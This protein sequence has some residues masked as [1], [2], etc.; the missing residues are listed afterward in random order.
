MSAVY[1]LESP[2]HPG[3][4]L[5]RKI[6]EP[7]NLTVMS[8]ASV[9]GVTRQFLSEFLNEKIDLN[10]DLAFRIEKVFGF[11]ME[12]M[13]AMQSRFDIAKVRDR[14]RRL[15]NELSI[16]AAQM[17]KADGRRAGISPFN[18]GRTRAAG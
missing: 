3:G 18:A 10:A 7:R 17:T 13:M 1:R 5:R 6:F 14:E 2:S 12:M 16:K 4:F 9:L 15:Q 11:N 8:T